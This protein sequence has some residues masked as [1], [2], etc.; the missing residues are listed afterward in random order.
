[1]HGAKPFFNLCSLRWGAHGGIYTRRV[2]VLCNIPPVKVHSEVLVF[3]M[4]CPREL[5]RQQS[6]E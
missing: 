4:H 5:R 1:M 6:S 3:G 2:R